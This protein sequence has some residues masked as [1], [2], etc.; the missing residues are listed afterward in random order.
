[1]L[2]LADRVNNCVERPLNGKPLPGQQRDGGHCELHAMARKQVPVGG[3]VEGD[4]L[5][6]IALL[7]RAA[8]V[9]KGRKC[10]TFIACAA[11]VMMARAC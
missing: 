9:V 6:E 8:D 7:D 4:Q 11:T 10:M 5:K 1:V 2:T 3:R